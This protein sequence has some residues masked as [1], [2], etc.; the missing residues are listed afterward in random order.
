MFPRHAV[1]QRNQ[2]DTYCAT[3]LKSQMQFLRSNTSAAFHEYH[4]FSRFCRWRRNT[5]ETNDRTKARRWLR[6][7]GC[8]YWTRAEK[9]CASDSRPFISPYARAIGLL[10]AIELSIRWISR[11]STR[12]RQLKQ[13]TV[14]RFDC[15]SQALNPFRLHTSGL[16]PIARFLFPLKERRALTEVLSFCQIV[17]SFSV[18]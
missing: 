15:S 16:C 3:S 6:R 4:R 9:G 11:F 14:L 7:S 10:E 8:M 17:R 5:V 1:E 13:R 12:C 2:P 18:Y